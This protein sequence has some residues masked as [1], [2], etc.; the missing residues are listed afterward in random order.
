MQHFE[1]MTRYEECA[2]IFSVLFEVLSE[3]ESAFG[4]E[5]DEGFVQD[6]ESGFSDERGGHGNFSGHAARV[7]ANELMTGFSE[8]AELEQ[9]FDL[10][11]S[12]ILIQISY[13][14]HESQKLLARQ[15]RIDLN[16]LW[17]EA[18]MFFC[19]DGVCLHVITGDGDGAFIDVEQAGNGAHRRRFTGAV[20]PD[21]GDGL[22]GSDRHGEVID[23]GYFSIRFCYIFN[24]ENTHDA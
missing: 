19:F 14:S 15:V 7:L 5:P 21:E 4:I 17:D 10:S 11:V 2:T 12:L 3:F 24:F 6:D 16:L 13:F 20:R 18:Q 1:N 8:I 22:T 9:F 23:G